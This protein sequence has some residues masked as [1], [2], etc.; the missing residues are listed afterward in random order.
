MN[1]NDDALLKHKST[2]GKLGI[3]SKF[4]KVLTKYDLSVAYTPGI[5]AVSSL[6]AK[7]PDLAREYT[8]KGNTIA[9]VSDG[10]AVLGLGD[11][12]PLG[13]LPVMEGK[14]ILMKELAGVD[15]FPI[16]LDVHDVAGIVAAVK[17]IAPT[18][19]G[20]NLE[21]IAAP[22]CFEIEE[23]LARELNIPV[24]HDDQHATAIV[25]LAALINALQ[26]AGKDK[27][28]SKVVI[29]GAGAAG[30]ATARLL[31]AYGVKN[32]ILCDS[33]G[34]LHDQRTDLNDAKKAIV[35]EIG[36]H[37]TATNL[38]EALVGADVFIGLSVAGALDAAWIQKMATKP[39]IFAL[40]NPVPEIMPESA[41]AAGAFIVG[42]GRSD[43]ANQIN[44]VL[45]FPG[46]FRGLIDKKV[47]KVNM[48]M[49]LRVAQAIASAIT[50]ED[51]RTDYIIPH[52]LDMDVASIVAASI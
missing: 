34:A 1:Y 10:S 37:C 17:A 7:E 23:I 28:V 40:A 21:D 13:A 4:G 24:F 47:L 26:L 38:A 8:M 27:A 22:K 43:F 36:L 39:I 5:G 45:V 52:P 41:L 32:I 49:K 35:Q 29:N 11:I 12:G 46:L 18:F 33:K 51:L 44:N 31:L 14:A 9:V 20:I 3:Y 30:I 15:A 19:A 48:E 6:I 2:R 50:K 25:A 42:T 16:V